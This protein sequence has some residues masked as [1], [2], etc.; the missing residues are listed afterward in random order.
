MDNFLVTRT[1]HVEAAHFLPKVPDSHK[2]RRVHGHNYR[3]DVTVRGPLDERGFVVDFFELD[4]VIEP[5]IAALDHRIIN[6][7]AGLENPTAE[8]IARWFFERI[9]LDGVSIR[10]F[11][12]ADCSAEFAP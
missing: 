8:I 7:V 6:E 10:V 3:V 12:T 9:A 4:A 1:Y 5:L 2:C 11:E